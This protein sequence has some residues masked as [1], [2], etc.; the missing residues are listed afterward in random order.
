VGGA[1]RKGGFPPILLR[2]VV[3]VACCPPRRPI[4]P[5]DTMTNYDARGSTLPSSCQCNCA[6]SGPTD[7]ERLHVEGRGEGCEHISIRQSDPPRAGDWPRASRDWADHQPRRR[8]A[9]PRKTAALLAIHP[10]RLWSSASR[11]PALGEGVSPPPTIKQPPVRTM[12]QEQL[13]GGAVGHGRT[14]PPLLSSPWNSW[15]LII[16]VRAV[17][18]PSLS[19]AGPRLSP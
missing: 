5:Q 14:S 4:P 11:G 6:A 3:S 1:P 9:K 19:R 12:V 13:G 7:W 10:L 2:T 18:Q 15:L 17:R 16:V 8:R